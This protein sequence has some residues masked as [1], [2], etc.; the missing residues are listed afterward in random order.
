MKPEIYYIYALVHNPTQKVYIGCSLHADRVRSHMT[1]LKANRH[2]NR[3]MQ[4]DCNQYGFDYSAYLIEFVESR[5][6][7]P[8]KPHE[9]EAYWIRYYCTDDPKYGY[10]SPKW[11]KRISI[12]SFPEIISCDQVQALI[13]AQKKPTEALAPAPSESKPSR[14]HYRKKN[15]SVALT[16]SY[17]TY[18]KYKKLKGVNDSVVAKNTGIGKSTLTEWKYGKFELGREKLLRICGFLGIPREEMFADE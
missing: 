1:A 7:S 16:H 4:E 12:T 14:K 18:L 10:N 2:S 3:Y 5:T 8:E 9:R 11:Y 15:N 13:D 17:S 6:F